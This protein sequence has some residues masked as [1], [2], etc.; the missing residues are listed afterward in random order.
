VTGC[1]ENLLKLPL[2]GAQPSSTI[3]KRGKVTLTILISILGGLRRI[4]S[5]LRPCRIKAKT[6]SGG[7][8]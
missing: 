2:Y 6:E 3:T 7:D 1:L 8:K 5:P 4:V